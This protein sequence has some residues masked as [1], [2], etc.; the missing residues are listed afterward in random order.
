MGKVRPLWFMTGNL[1]KLAE[2]QQVLGPQGYQ[3]TQ[4]LIDG[5]IPEILELQSESLKVVAKEKLRQAREILSSLGRGDEAVGQPH[6]PGS[7]RDAQ[8]Q[9][10]AGPVVGSV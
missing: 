5:K 6:A 9:V 3:V 8:A 7:L 1:G 10:H 4:F 2:A